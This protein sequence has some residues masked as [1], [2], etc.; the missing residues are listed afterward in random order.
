MVSLLDF[1][2]DN[3]LFRQFKVNDLL[4]VEYKCV[5]DEIKLKVW[6]K[7]NYFIYV[8]SGKKVWQTLHSKYEVFSGEAIFVKKG[9][10]IVHQFLDKD[11]CALII[12]VPDS[13]ISDIIKH[14]DIRL[15][16]L[17]K[18]TEQSDSVVPIQPDPVLTAYFQ[19][20]YTYFGNEGTPPV[21]LLE[22]KFKE[23]ILNILSSRSNEVLAAYFLSLCEGNRACMREIMERNY[24]FNMKLE[25]FARLSGRSLTSF[26]R[27]FITTFKTTPGKWLAHKKLEYARHLLETTDKNI[28]ELT[29]ESG[30]E[31]PSHFI[32]I[33]KQTFQVTP[34]Q[35]KKTILQ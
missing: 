25:E 1:V 11:F 14:C 5:V 28:N 16:Y 32:R 23:L 22:L 30:F 19:S 8:L 33:F 20:V 10:N 35:Y 17:K 15:S 3:C 31:N 29:F 18:R 24:I 4:F 13:F 7:H 9:A 21:S 6:S 12:F 26:K 2:Y 34:L 27:D